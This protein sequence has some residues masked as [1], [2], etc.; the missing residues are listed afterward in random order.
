LKSRKYPAEV[1]ELILI[2][3]VSSL[4]WAVPPLAGL[5]NHEFLTGAKRFAT[6][7]PFQQRGFGCLGS[8]LPRRSLIL[9]EML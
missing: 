8:E 2:S 3:K 5:R 6:I 9:P 4:W 1:R 7:S